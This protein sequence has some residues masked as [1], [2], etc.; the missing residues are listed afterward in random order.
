MVH[1]GQGELDDTVYSTLGTAS[2]LRVS[3]TD[4]MTYIGKTHKIRYSKLNYGVGGKET[5]V[6]VAILQILWH[7]RSNRAAESVAE[8]TC[9]RVIPEA[10]AA[11]LDP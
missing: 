8:N 5:W 7:F 1:F 11:K 2:F 9:C 10:S 3:S 6:M 4:I